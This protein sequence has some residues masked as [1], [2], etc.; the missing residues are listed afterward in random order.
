M[1]QISIVSSLIILV[2]FV[3]TVQAQVSITYSSRGKQHFTMSLPDE[4]RVNVGSGSDPVRI[5]EEGVGPPRVISA[6]PNDGVPLWFGMWVPEELEKIQ[7]A[8]AYMAS[9]ELDLLDDVV[10]TKRQSDRWNS[11]D[12][13][14][15]AGTGK[16]EGKSMDFHAAFIQLSPDIVAIAIYIGPREATMSYGEELTQMVHS[17]RPVTQ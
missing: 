5:D 13:Y 6:M 9:L 3:A 7:D 2:T 4:W 11:L 14:H 10:T 17:L 8:E 1:R 16:K 15:V 12:F